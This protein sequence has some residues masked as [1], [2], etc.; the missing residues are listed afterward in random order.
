MY[1][2]QINLFFPK[3]SSLCTTVTAFMLCDCHLLKLYLLDLGNNRDV[4]AEI[5]CFIGY[6]RFI[7]I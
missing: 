3:D 1:V 5:N 7:F 2:D 6:F 4:M